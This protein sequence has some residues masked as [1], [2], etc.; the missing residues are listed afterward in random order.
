MRSELMDH[1]TVSPVF[2][3]RWLFNREGKSRIQLHILNVSAAFC[4]GCDR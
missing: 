3:Q 2:N 1:R 4:R